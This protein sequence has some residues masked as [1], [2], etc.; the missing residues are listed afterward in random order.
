MV[1]LITRSRSTRYWEGEKK[2]NAGKL[3]VLNR[4]GRQMVQRSHFKAK[5]IREELARMNSAL[6]SLVE[7]VKEQ[8]SKLGQAESQ[9]DHNRMTSDI[10]TKIRDSKSLMNSTGSGDDM[11]GYKKR[12]SQHTAAVAELFAVE[13]LENFHAR[14][15]EYKLWVS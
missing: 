13:H 2:A 10:K 7:A 6:E 14:F 8:G 9:S 12:L 4:T 3:K 1:T 15:Q 11:R 5:E